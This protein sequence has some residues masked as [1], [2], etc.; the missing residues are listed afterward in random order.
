MFIN[1]PIAILAC[2]ICFAAQNQIRMVK[3][4]VLHILFN[5]IR[6]EPICKWHSQIDTL[7]ES[8]VLRLPIMSVPK[9]I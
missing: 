6:F 1:V 5:L 2:Y 9:L 4:V 7:C 8:R 3:I